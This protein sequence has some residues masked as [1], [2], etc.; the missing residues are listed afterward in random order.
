MTSFVSELRR[1]NVLRVAAAYA[2]VA[3]IIIEAGSVLLPTFGASDTA[4]QTYV[5]V[6]LL[7]FFVSL[8]F[9][10]IFEITPDGV[11]LDKDV[12]REAQAES[13]GGLTNYAIIGL[14]I[15]ALAVSVT[16]NVADIQPGGEPSAADI[17]MNRQS[18]AVL[19]FSSRSSVAD[20]ILFADGVH[21]DL[22]TKL[23]NLGSLKV[24]SR[25][26]VMEYR[27]TTKNLRQ[28]GEELDVDTLLEGSVQQI[29]ANVRINVQLI[30]AETDEHL[31]ARIYDRQLTTENIFTVQS[32]VS[33]E[34]AAA[35]HTT[36]MPDE[37]IQAADV[38]T[39]NLRAYSL[40]KSGRDNLYQRRLEPL[41][42]ARTQFEQAI[43]LDPEYAEPYAWRS[44]TSIRLFCST[45]NWPMPMRRSGFSKHQYG[46]SPASALK[47]SRQKRPLN[48]RWPLTRITPKRTCGLQTCAT[49]NNRPTR[50]SATFIA[51]CNSTHWAGY[52]TTISRRFMHNVARMNSP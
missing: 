4:F 44:N 1:R 41:R 18:I 50:R 6:V 13:K 51:P 7:G 12:D 17:M 32:E 40:Y 16:F 5:I 9:A 39:Q 11:K 48:R 38:P 52:R 14:L 2:L 47:T 33:A 24:I 23:A 28:I 29:G 15:V 49:Q 27:D 45:R 25:T 37:Q 21:D 36:L 8:I 43:E 22:L 3:W 30:D 35:L 42:E 20:N 31:W 34:I 46:Q 19:P 26:S 10:W